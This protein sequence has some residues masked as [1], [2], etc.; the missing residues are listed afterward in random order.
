MGLGDQSVLN[1]V[2]SGEDAAKRAY[3]KALASTL[4]EPV[5]MV[6]QRQAESVFHAHDHVRDLR[7]RDK[8]A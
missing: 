2:E 3:Q 7:D 4:P 6:I 8:A 1:S 5:R